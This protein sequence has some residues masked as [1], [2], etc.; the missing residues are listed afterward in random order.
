[1]IKA[2]QFG[3]AA[4]LEKLAC[5]YGKA[6]KNFKEENKLINKLNFLKTAINERSDYLPKVEEL[7]TK[8]SNLDFSKESL[9]T[10]TLLS[11]IDAKR[12]EK[13]VV[14]LQDMKKI[15]EANMNSLKKSSYTLTF[16]KNELKNM[17]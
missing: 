10:E 14:C 15:F 11:D 7:K 12:L 2:K 16:M 3:V 13:S 5:L 1:M 4:K 6:E 8:A 9:D 17:K